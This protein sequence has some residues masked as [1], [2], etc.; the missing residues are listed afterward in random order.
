MTNITDQRI[1]QLSVGAGPVPESFEARF[2]GQQD[3]KF[4]ELM[5]FYFGCLGAGLYA[6]S[7]L[8][9]WRAAG[10]APRATVTGLIV[11]FI[12]VIVIKNGSHILGSSHPGKA[13]RALSQVGSSWISR[14]S[15]FILL[16]GIFGALDVVVRLGWIPGDK[17]VLGWIL[18]ILALAA[19]VA[20]MVYVGFVMAQGR[21][22]SLW[23]SP[24]MPVIFLVYSVVVGCALATGIFVIFGIAYDTELVRVILLIGIPVMMF[25]VLAQ[26][27]FLGTSTEAGRISL[28]MLTRGRLAAGYI[29]GAFILGLVI[30]LILTAAAYGTSGGEAVASVIS[31]VLIVIGGYLFF[32]SLLKAAVYTPAVEPGRSVLVNI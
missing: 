1:E 4:W 20:V 29:G 14:G 6:I 27:A 19:S 28:R 11:G 23:H 7:S 9:D 13:L 32:S 30:P 15:L 18:G 22:I 31:A 17:D 3:W 12:L 16:F 26:L 24:L 21:R 25:L 10:D 8:L 5:A 2:F